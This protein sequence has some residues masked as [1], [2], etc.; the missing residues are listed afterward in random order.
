[1][2]D[3]YR[4]LAIAQ[5]DELV[6]ICSTNATLCKQ[7]Y[8]FIINQKKDFLNEIGTFKNVG[9]DQAALLSHQIESTNVVS[10]TGFAKR[11][12]QKYGIDRQ[13]AD[14]IASSVYGA[15]T[16]VRKTSTKAS[17]SQVQGDRPVNYTSTGAGRN[18]AFN[19]A[20]KMLVFLSA[21]NPQE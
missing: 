10:S 15:L 3:K 9:S 8:T 12:Q 13:E 6:A 20:K 2:R 19:Q 1:M 16:G 5:Q 14:L 4:K 7:K 21:C 11:L 18:G 17:A